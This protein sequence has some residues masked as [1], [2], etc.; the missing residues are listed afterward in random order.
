MEK[1]LYEAI[2]NR[3]SNY[4]LTGAS[5]I[6]D[7][8]IREIVEFCTMHTPSAFNSQ[9]ARVCL[10]LGEQHG[11]L[12]D[13]VLEELR[14]IVPA[15]KFAPTA[16]KIAGFR[17]GHGTVL[18]FEELKTV[19]ELQEEFPLYKDH[20]PVWSTQACGMLQYAIWTALAAEGLAVNLQH[21]NPLIDGEVARAWGIDPDWKLV[22]QMPFGAPSAGPGPKEFMD[23]AERVK[24]FA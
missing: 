24:V 19:R 12:W 22:A 16:E 11:K 18:F 15:G 4:N 17:A 10:L 14:K 1:S 13:I 8:R 3:R 21:Y 7:P 5:P 9:N 2:E 20:F 23:I 6:G